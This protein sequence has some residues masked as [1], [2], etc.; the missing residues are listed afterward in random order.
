MNKDLRIIKLSYVLG[1]I[2][3]GLWAVAFLFPP[4][5]NLLTNNKNF[6][7][8]FETRIIMGIA[9]SLMLGWTVLMIWA[10]LK[11]LERRFIL[12]LTAFPVVLCL[13]VL[14]LLSVLNGNLFAIWLLFKTLLIIILM[15]YSYLKANR[16]VRNQ[17][18]LKEN[19]HIQ[20]DISEF[21]HRN[22]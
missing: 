16:I 3:D 11:P 2:A 19:L 6:N 8:D 1:I 21:V 10:L 20:Y 22:T 12:I 13:F 5:F 17:K 14:S 15:T 7:P 4:L 9:A 18:N